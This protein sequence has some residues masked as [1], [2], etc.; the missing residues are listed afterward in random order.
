VGVPNT[1]YE[2]IGEEIVR[3]MVLLALAGLLIV[4]LVG[5]GAA[6]SVTRPVRRIIEGLT[7]GS[8]DLQQVSAQI[9]TG[10][11]SLSAGVSQQAANLEETS[12]SLEEMASMTRINAEHAQNANRLIQEEA[13]PNFR[14]V[15]SEMEAMRDSVGA[16]AAAGEETGKIIKSIDGIALQTNLLALNAAV[17]A[18]R[19][20]EAGAGFAVVADEVRHLAGRA[21]EAAG[22]SQEW[23]ENSKDRVREAGA[24]AYQV[25]SVME[26]NL[27]LAGTL[28]E[29]MEG[30][31]A[32]SREQALGFEQ[33]SRTMA[34]MDQVVQRNAAQARDFPAAVG[35]MN[36]QSDRLQF[37][38]NQ[39]HALVGR[40]KG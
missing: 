11:Q 1:R 13:A 36:E 22:H 20:G 26:V 5:Y 32:A 14:R 7:Q 39:L 18:A 2:R 33:I 23:I 8:A 35:R 37:F 31:A 27:R 9:L 21:K 25:S 16:V 3:R 6:A 17:E 38:V 19:A 30:I 29:L 4:A 34:E 12:A 28:E 15:A 10:S 24:V 40:R